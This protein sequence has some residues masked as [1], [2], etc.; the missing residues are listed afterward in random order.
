[1]NL[2][3]GKKSVKHHSKNYCEENADLL[4]LTCIEANEMR[5]TKSKGCIFIHMKDF[6]EYFF[7]LF[8]KGSSL[9]TC[10]RH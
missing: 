2:L 7:F 8:F 10:D 4:I 6:L 3:S 1:M 9:V 5:K